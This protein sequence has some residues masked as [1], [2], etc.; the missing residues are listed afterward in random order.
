MRMRSL[1]TLAGIVLLVGACADS[2]LVSD[3]SQLKPKESGFKANLHKE[4]VDLAKAELAE[5][6]TRDTGV[7]ARNAEAAAMG[8]SVDPDK[9]WDRSYN[10]KHQTVLFD[11]RDRLLAALDGGGRANHGA[12][13]ARAQAMFDCWAQEQEE[14]NQPPDIER[15]RSGYMKAMDQLAAAM[16][17]KPAP[18]MAAKP[19]PKPKKKAKKKGVAIENPYVVYFDYDSTTIANM[20][21]VRQITAAAKAAKSNKSTR[22]EVTGHTDT[23]GASAYNQKLSEARAKVVDEALVAL[24]INRLIIERHAS[25]ENEP[26]VNTG[27]GV[28]KGENR[29]VEI[30][31]R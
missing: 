29:R 12:I 26:D 14:N 13:A 6:D 27:D 10:K 19:K 3:V 11:E 15:C 4:Y 17:P 24:K 20:E 5:G 31:V 2:R 23:S 22:I 16:K 1:A 9:L 30:N 28:R 18:K 8:K 25:G 21:S 7:F